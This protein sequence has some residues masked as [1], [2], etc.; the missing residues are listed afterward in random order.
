[1]VH[2]GECEGGEVGRAQKGKR[3]KEKAISQ[4]KGGKKKKK[5]EKKGEKQIVKK[6]H[7]KTKSLARSRCI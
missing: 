2:D 4:R 5:K 3:K 6:E 1:M 7:T